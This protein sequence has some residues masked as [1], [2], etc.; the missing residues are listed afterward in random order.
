MPSSRT[1]MLDGVEE[2]SSV[3]IF[4]IVSIC[5]IHLL[6]YVDDLQVGVFRLIDVCVSNQHTHEEG[7]Q[8]AVEEQRG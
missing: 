5:S 3:S 2:L 4:V 8:P 1:N 6:E 7:T